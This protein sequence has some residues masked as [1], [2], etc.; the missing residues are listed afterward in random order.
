MRTGQ[1]LPSF[2]SFHAWARQSGVWRHRVSPVGGF[3]GKRLGA[4]RGDQQVEMS[5]VQGGPRGRH[6][7]GWTTAGAGGGWGRDHAPQRSPCPQPQDTQ[8]HSL[9]ALLKP[10]MDYL[11]LKGGQR[12]ETEPREPVTK[13]RPF[14]PQ[15]P[16]RNKINGMCLSTIPRGLGEG[17]GDVG[18]F[19]PAAQ[20]LPH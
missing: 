3:P 6:D 8:T 16:F 20:L 15:R 17:W 18:A 12:G 10:T 2:P 9:G 1:E 7:P 14:S 13:T 19:V 11:G 5:E 4:G